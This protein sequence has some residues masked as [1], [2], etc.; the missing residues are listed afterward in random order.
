[1]GRIKLSL[2]CI[3]VSLL[4]GGSIPNLVVYVP[5]VSSRLDRHGI[6]V[7]YY[8]QRC[9]IP[10]G[11]DVSTWLTTY[12]WHRPYEE[13]VW[14]CSEMSAYTEF[15]LENCGYQTDIVLVSFDRAGHAFIRV[16][17][18]GVWRTYEATIRK[19]FPMHGM[20]HPRLAFRSIYQL[21]HFYF[22]NG[23]FFKE[24]AWY[25]R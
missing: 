14:D 9:P 25:L 8:S 1:M 13:H 23:D 20:I 22:D 19:W 15:A 18:D 16:E 17:I 24:W 21:R 5:N 11:V 10:W 4:V 12:R 7:D 2:M 3:M 6:P